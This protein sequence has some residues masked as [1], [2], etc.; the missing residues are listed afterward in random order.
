MRRRA[1]ASTRRILFVAAAAA[2]VLLG[3]GLV[4]VFAPLAFRGL[5]TGEL[6][7]ILGLLVLPPLTVWAM[8]AEC[9][10]ARETAR[11]GNSTG[12]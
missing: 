7:A 4:W 1:R 9:R 5:S 11:A 2:S 8:L 3:V 10:V 12:K 6:L